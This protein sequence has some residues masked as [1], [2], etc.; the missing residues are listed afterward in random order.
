MM[1]RR[2]SLLL[3]TGV[4]CVACGAS[5]DDAAVDTAATIDSETTGVSPSSDV[6][7]TSVDSRPSDSRPIDSSEGGGADGDAEDFCAGLIEFQSNA[8]PEAA[9]DEE[10]IARVR[11]LEDDAPDRV[12]NDLITF[13]DVIEEL[14]ALDGED[15]EQAA[16]LFELAG[17]P[18]FLEASE[19]LNRFV[20]D[21]CGLEPTEPNSI[22]VETG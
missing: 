2:L 18:E 6:A 4:L 19:N 11:A 14:A 7:E 8:A 20:V 3:S 15:P 1:I 21:E 17:S 5:D 13:L 9:F 12:R 10:A 22:D 16:E